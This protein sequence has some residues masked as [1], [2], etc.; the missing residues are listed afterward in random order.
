[1]KLGMTG[2]FISQAT[3]VE[4]QDNHQSTSLAICTH[5]SKN[6]AA[7]T[8]NY[9]INSSYNITKLLS[10]EQKNCEKLQRVEKYL[11][12]MACVGDAK[13]KSLRSFTMFQNYPKRSL[14]DTVLI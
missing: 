9:I 13:C 14:F 1:M 4:L 11:L 2:S 8:Q 7:N 5:K 3:E 12:K 10:Y 6:T